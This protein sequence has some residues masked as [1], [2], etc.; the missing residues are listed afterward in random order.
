M[1]KLTPDTIRK[2]EFLKRPEP[3]QGIIKIREGHNHQTES[4]DALSYLRVTEEVQRQFE[5]Y[6]KSGCGASQAHRIYEDKLMLEDDGIVKMANASLNPKLRTVTYL[7]T[8]WRKSEYGQA[9]LEKSSIE[10][11]KAKQAKYEDAGKGSS[12]YTNSEEKNKK[13]SN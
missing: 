12:K 11:L 8:K 7:H 5:E 9:W 13:N 2:D 1:K 10:V 3:L 4:F 6:F